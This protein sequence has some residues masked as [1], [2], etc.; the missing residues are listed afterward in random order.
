MRNTF[1]VNLVSELVITPLK[2]YMKYMTNA[3]LLHCTNWVLKGRGDDLILT[4]V[5]CIM[6]TPKSVRDYTTQSASA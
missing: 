4:P 5:S 1:P 2:F 3:S 6:L